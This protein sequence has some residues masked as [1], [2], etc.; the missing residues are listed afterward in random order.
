M[1][2]ADDLIEG[3]GQLVVLNIHVDVQ[4]PDGPILMGWCVA[5]IGVLVEDSLLIVNPSLTETK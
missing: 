4:P 1:F 3:H 5:I 2:S